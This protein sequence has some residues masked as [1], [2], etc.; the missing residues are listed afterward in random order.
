MSRVGSTR[1]ARIAKRAR[2][3]VALASFDR[4]R[5]RGRRLFGNGEA[6]AESRLMSARLEST[7]RARSLTLTRIGRVTRGACFDCSTT[8][9]ADELQASCGHDGCRVRY[10]VPST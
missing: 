1:I 2:D 9:A 8:A 7:L 5:E 6:A 3:A 4:E 10:S